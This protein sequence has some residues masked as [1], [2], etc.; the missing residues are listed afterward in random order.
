VNITAK[1]DLIKG[2]LAGE[3]EPLNRRERRVWEQ[4]Q[5]TEARRARR[6]RA[7]VEVAL[8]RFPKEALA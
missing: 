8:S 3:R 6:A 2:I 5:R 1:Q 7:R 4:H